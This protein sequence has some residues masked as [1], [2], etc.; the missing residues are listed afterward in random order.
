MAAIVNKV[1]WSVEKFYIFISLLIFIFISNFNLEP[2]LNFLKLYSTTGSRICLTV[3]SILYMLVVSKGH[4]LK[5]LRKITIKLK[6]SHKYAHN[7]DSMFYVLD[8]VINNSLKL[9]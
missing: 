7:F 1:Y 3:D 2:F 9:L 4:A 5:N 8:A 6:Q